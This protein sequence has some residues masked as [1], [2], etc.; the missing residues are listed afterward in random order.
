MEAW[1][2]IFP[3]TTVSLRE[4]SLP[5]TNSAWMEWDHPWWIFPSDKP[6]EAKARIFNWRALSLISLERSLN[7]SSQVENIK[8]RKIWIVEVGTVRC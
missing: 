2:L 6:T 8:E 7:E 1:K 4:G 5:L 3:V